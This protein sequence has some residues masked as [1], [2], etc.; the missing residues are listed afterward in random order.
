MPR[1][2]GLPRL[3]EVRE[4]K[5]AEI[6]LALELGLIHTPRCRQLKDDFDKTQVRRKFQIFLCQ[7]DFYDRL[8]SAIR[9]LIKEDLRDGI[10]RDLDD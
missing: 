8:D 3:E 2:P 10:T 5:P 9:E 1:V 6:V 4:P 7:C